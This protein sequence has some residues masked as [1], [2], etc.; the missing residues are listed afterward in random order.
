MEAFK[1]KD[2]HLFQ[3]YEQH[4]HKSCNEIHI[5]CFPFSFV[6]SSSLSAKCFGACRV[7]MDSRHVTYSLPYNKTT[8][9]PFQLPWMYRVM[10]G[11][12]LIVRPTTII[13]KLRPAYNNLFFRRR[14]AGATAW[15]QSVAASKVSQ[16]RRSHWVQGTIAVTILLQTNICTHIL[17]CKGSSLNLSQGAEILARNTKPTS[18]RAQITTRETGT[19]YPQTLNSRD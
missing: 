9:F 12:E 3:K 8:H 17:H 7:P 18:H 15:H 19:E 5:T 10:A 16:S 11:S 6:F 2:K 13:Q 1:L 14:T 4:I